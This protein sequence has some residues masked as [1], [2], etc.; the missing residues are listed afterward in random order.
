MH[1]VS[2]KALFKAKATPSFT[3]DMLLMSQHSAKFH[4]HSPHTPSQ[5]LAVLA[6]LASCQGSQVASTKGKSLLGG[7][8]VT[9]TTMF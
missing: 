1:N 4:K 5:A 6:S 3:L 8:M 2:L 7:L 9:A